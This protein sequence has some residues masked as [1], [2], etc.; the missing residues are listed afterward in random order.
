M[1]PTEVS[2]YNSLLEQMGS[3]DQISDHCVVISDIT[4]FHFALESG[5]CTLPKF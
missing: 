5:L 3:R 4:H 1:F 2:K